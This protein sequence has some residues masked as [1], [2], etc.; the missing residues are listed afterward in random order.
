MLKPVYALVG[1]DTFLQLQR[2]ADLMQQA[3]EDAQRIDI[4]GERAELVDVLD[5]L[6][7][8][9][10]FGGYKVVI[11]R[12]AEEFISRYREQVEK[13]LAAPVDSATLILRCEALV[14]TTR[15]YK[16]I[17]KLGGIL[18]CKPPKQLASWIATQAKNAHGLTL[19]SEVSRLL[20]EL[21][22]DDLGRLDNELAK[23]ALTA[24]RGRIG[25]EDISGTV[26]FQKELEMVELTNALT[27]GDA[28][29][30]IRRWRQ[31]TQLDPG[32]EYRVFTWLAVWLSGVRK[33]LRMKS[34]G[35]GNFEVYR[36]A[37]IWQDEL[38]EP[39][40]RTM[41]AMGE[42]GVDRAMAQL[43]QVEYQSKTG[44]G[45][46]TENVERFI[47]SLPLKV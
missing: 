4:D 36:E 30:A 41:Q 7:M 11:V 19:S 16:L 5:E 2:Q 47:L 35:A 12:D 14:S 8:F 26:A 21:V 29:E 6:R 40:L 1:P 18:D 10:M 31:L 3:P 28:A 22:G 45:S 25:P 34:R 27:G 33:A 44:I 20:A 15:V 37:R 9:A 23:L 43:A 24:K 42:D 46:A 13:Y 32:S 38:K 17:D 39:F